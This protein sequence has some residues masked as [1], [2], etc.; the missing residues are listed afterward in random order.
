L[1]RT[2]IIVAAVLIAAPLGGT[3][4]P[5]SGHPVMGRLGHG[6]HR[7]GHGLGGSLHR[8]GHRMSHAGHGHAG[9]H[10]G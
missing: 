1:T 7:L 2:L 5:A 3:A 8:L 4:S 6:L 10:R 9:H